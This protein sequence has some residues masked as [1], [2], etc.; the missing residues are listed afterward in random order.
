M[1]KLIS[2][3]GLKF[4]P[5]IA[6]EVKASYSWYQEQAHGLGDDYFDEL[7][8][9]FQTIVELPD[10]WPLFQ[11][12]FRR[13]LLARFPFSVNRKNDDVIYVVAVM[14]NSRRPGYWLSRR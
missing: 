5:A 12:G 2:M 13:Y 14:H 7:E 3:A 10:T 11:K 4:H 9:A 1:G 8:A 6:T